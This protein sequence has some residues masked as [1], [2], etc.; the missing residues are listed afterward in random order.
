MRIKVKVGLPDWCI[1]EYSE[2]VEEIKESTIKEYIGKFAKIGAKPEDISVDIVETDGEFYTNIEVEGADEFQYPTPH[3][4]PHGEE[5]HVEEPKPSYADGPKGHSVPEPEDLGCSER[6]SD[7]DDIGDC[8]L[9]E[10][11]LAYPCKKVI[12]SLEPWER[13]LAM[14]KLWAMLD[15]DAPEEVHTK[16]GTFILDESEKA[17][18]K[19]MLDVG[20]GANAQIERFKEYLSSWK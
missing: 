9:W 3:E 20:V 10:N 6:T 12:R 4:A 16:H 1:E 17:Y 14:V 19:S 15:Y 18:L 2:D 13:K 5:A 8:K 11:L 7:D